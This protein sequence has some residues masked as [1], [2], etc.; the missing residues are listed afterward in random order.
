M[1][2]PK[3]RPVLENAK[4]GFL[5]LDNILNAP[6]RER[7]SKISGYVLIFY[8]D[9]S[10]FLFLKKG[11]PINAAWLSAEEK[12]LIA[13]GDLI[14]RA[15]GAY[16][17]VVSIY[18]VEEE[19]VSMMLTA[20]NSEPIYKQVVEEAPESSRFLKW[21]EDNSPTG[22]IELTSRAEVCYIAVQKGKLLRAYIPSRQSR[23]ITPEGFAQLVS[24]DGL[25]IHVYRGT[26]QEIEQA[27]PALMTLFLKM[28]NG[29]IQEFMEAVGPTLVE[30]F[31][32]SS[33]KEAEG[34]FPLVKE[35]NLDREMKV[36]GQSLATPEELTQS[37]AK[38]VSLFLESF[39]SVLGPRHEEIVKKGIKD[40]R[41][42]VKSTGFFD[43]FGLDRY[44]E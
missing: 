11:E 28:Y 36:A 39:D 38:W 24:R 20:L 26:P 17:G 9:H 16:N 15:K 44:F 31:V 35:F 10:E 14:E 34:D 6:K 33:K 43:H 2:F 27:S 42:A 4:L 5:N 25:V 8:P 7:A 40:Y 21:L 18:E 3:G 37:F 1:K 41:F 30:K 12:R 22:V 13:I 29:L 19:L 23:E 32:S